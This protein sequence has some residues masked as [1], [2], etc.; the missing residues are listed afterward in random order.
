V[1]SKFN[2]AIVF[3]YEQKERRLN[4]KQKKVNPFV[5]VKVL[6]NRKLWNT[7]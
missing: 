1:F 2:E 5:Q 6:E 4:E 3:S 7:I